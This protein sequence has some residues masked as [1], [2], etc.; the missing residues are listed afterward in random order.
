[1]ASHTSTP[2]C[3]DREADLV[4]VGSSSGGLVAAIRGHDLG[5]STV[6]LERADTLGGGTSFSRGIIWI[7]CNHHM[8]D[9]GLFDSRDEALTYVRR[10]SFG[11]HD[12]RQLAAYLD[13][14][15]EMVR[16]IEEHTP[17]KLA[18]GPYDVD[19]YADFPGGKSKGRKLIPNP[20]IMPQVLTEAERVNPLLSKVRHE[21]VPLFLGT[22]EDVWTNGR[23]LIGG[24]VLGCLNRGIDIL[25]NTRANQ[26]VVRDGRVIGLRAESKSGHIYVKARRG[27]VL[28]TGGYEWN[29]E[30]NKRFI[31]SPPL[32]GITP[33]SCEGDGHTM[34]MEVGAAIALMDHTIFNPAIRIPGEEC[35]GKPYYRL[36][37]MSMGYPGSILVNRAGRRCC[38]ESFYPDIGRAFVAY[39]RVRGE[40]ANVPIF[41]IADQSFR[42]RLTIGPLPK[43]TQMTDWLRRGNTLLELAEQIGLP[44]DNLVETVKRFNSFALEG[45][46]PD[47]HRGES[48]HDKMWGRNY[49]RD[50]RPNH[51]LGPLEKPPFYGL[52][53]HL[54]T[55]GNLG[56]L[57]INDNAQVVDV[58]GKPITGLYGTGNATALLSH[59]FAYDSGSSQGKSMIFGYV[60]AEHMAGNQE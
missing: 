53:I 2:E 25:T 5:L 24:L 13:K 42:D 60:A 38:N 43:G 59:G 32:H 17:L 26:L 6:M 33:P 12:E 19:Y 15:P 44:A 34:G 22:P 9:M 18:V 23:A 57:V 50:D 8:L 31:N 4:A 49:F 11:R 47:F 41:W 29:D 55:V 58:R 54:G 36:F 7:P 27:I 14:G 48:T 37:M 45:R 21:P 51:A 16:Y 20:Q 3:W 30:M 52:Q 56:G 40:F 1:M 39:D 28:A 10:I 35:E 46:D